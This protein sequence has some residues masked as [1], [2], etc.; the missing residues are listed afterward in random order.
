M[1]PA[2]PLLQHLLSPLGPWLQDPATEDIA[3]NRPGEA[4]NRQ[5]GAWL[6]DKV[7]LDGEALEEIA[8]LAGSLRKQEVGAL[9]PLCATELPDG[10]RLQICLPPA[11]P[12][13]TVSLTIRKHKDRVA[14]LSKLASRYRARDWSRWR[15]LRAGR[16]MAELL[17]FYDAGDLESFLAA[18]V[19]ARLNML[20]SGRTGSGKTTLSKSVLAAIDPGER[21]ITIEDTLELTVL[22]PN[23]VRLLYSK[24][25]LSGAAVDAEALLQASLRTRPDRVLLQELRD[26]AAWTYINEVTSGHPGSVTTIHGHGASEA[27]RRLFALAKSSPKGA[28]LQDGT[29]IGLIAAAIDVIIPLEES[30]GVFGTGSVWFAAD[31]ARRGE[32]GRP[33]ARD[34]IPIPPAA[35]IVAGA[36]LYLATFTVLATLFFLVGTGLIGAFAH[37]FWQWWLYAL[38]Y[39]GNPVVRAWLEVSGVPAAALPLAVAGSI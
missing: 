30:G 37:P 3:V 4:W 32:T 31:A 36:G 9:S 1:S 28:A 7:A 33:P 11:V 29:L 6:R 10:E 38:W 2:A 27:F 19:R 25:G 26:D 16:D 14:P 20:L 15:H 5:R 12:Q 8:I 23:Q 39:S 13:G 35:W 34:M 18:A 22:Q 17:G 24:D 21:L